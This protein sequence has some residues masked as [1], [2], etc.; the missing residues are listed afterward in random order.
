MDL[1]P[2]ALELSGT[3]PQGLAGESL[4][5]IW[6]AKKNNERTYC[7]EH[8]GNKAIRKGNWKLVK[9]FEN[10]TWELYDVTTDP[11]ELKDLAS[12]EPVRVK[13]MLEEYLLWEKKMGVR[14]FVKGSGK[15]E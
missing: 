11:C 13:S 9:D 10:K 1:M 2:T 8:E 7:W 6:N 4:S 5:Y 12:N 15:G 3:Q 14:E